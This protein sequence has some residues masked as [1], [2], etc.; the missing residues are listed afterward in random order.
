[1]VRLNRALTPTVLAS[2][3]FP[4]AGDHGTFCTWSPVRGQ[5]A[6]SPWIWGRNPSDLFSGPR[7]AHG[8][9]FSVAP[10]SFN[11]KQLAGT[12]PRTLG[13]SCV[14]LGRL[15]SPLLLHSIGLPQTSW[16]LPEPAPATSGFKPGCV[17]RTHSASPGGVWTELR[18]PSAFPQPPP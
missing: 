13:T 2:F 3:S 1:M 17:G 10:R 5:A 12:S 18:D 14:S 6:P 11:L 7:L 9:C 16:R 8:P 4:P 15:P